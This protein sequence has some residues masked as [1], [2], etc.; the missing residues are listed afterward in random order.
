MHSGISPHPS[1]RAESSR[2]A[3]PLADR[4]P[5]QAHPARSEAIGRLGPLGTKAGLAGRLP[6]RRCLT[7][8]HANG[9]LTANL[10]ATMISKTAQY[11]ISAVLHIARETD[12][13]R[14]A[15][16]NEIAETLGVPRNYLSKILHVLARAGMLTSERG[17]RGGFRLARP[18]T[19][20]VLADLLVAIDPA[21]LEATCLL[22][23]PHCS[24]SSACA[25]HERW[26]QV[27]EPVSSFFRET[28]IADVS[29]GSPNKWS[30]V[31]GATG[32]ERDRPTR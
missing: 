5:L 27:R 18:A 9:T 30:L 28:T 17:P 1:P 13:G 29:K 4:G 20:L 7:Y 14:P 24:D 8:L 23:N 15:R 3:P 2:N 16:A 26:K 12:R 10:P 22:G 32:A 11:A 19:E 25:L 31:A 6:R 21:V